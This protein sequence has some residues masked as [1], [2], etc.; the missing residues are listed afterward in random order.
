M[1]NWLEK[2]ILK[3]VT[4]QVQK[5]MR[6]S[7]EL[8]QREIIFKSTYLDDLKSSVE[9][10]ETIRLRIPVEDVVCESIA[11]KNALRD[12]M[13][14]MEKEFVPRRM[15]DNTLKAV[16]PYIK[17]QLSKDNP[18]SLI[19][20]DDELT[21]IAGLKT[22]YNKKDQ[23]VV[24]MQIG[25]KLFPRPFVVTSKDQQIVFLNPCILLPEYF[26]KLNQLEGKGL[27]S[28]SLIGATIVKYFP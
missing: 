1:F 26:L 16:L 14:W 17:G 22:Q 23:C 18:F 8:L 27:L 10:I 24:T 12:G 21:V 4:Q 20:P 25:D 3:S 19:S 13:M 28:F 5:E 15:Y 7:K 6:E 11:F 2:R 9:A